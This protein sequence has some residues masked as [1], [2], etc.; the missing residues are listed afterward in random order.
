METF[1]INLPCHFDKSANAYYKTE[2]SQFIDLTGT[3][4]VGLSEI[5]F[6]KTWHNV[7]TKEH[8][9][10]LY[11]DINEPNGYGKSTN[12]EI[13]SISPGMYNVEELESLLKTSIRKNCET[14]EKINRPN[15][16]NFPE[17]LYPRFVYEKGKFKLKLGASPD[18]GYIF[19]LPSERLCELL[20]FDRN[21]IIVEAQ[22]LFESYIRKKI[23]NPHSVLFWYEKTNDNTWK[24]DKKY[25]EPKY[26]HKIEPFKNIYI[27]SD[28]CSDII[29]GSTKRNL[30]RIVNIP[31]TTKFG[32]NVSIIYDHPQHILINKTL[33]NSIDIKLRSD[34]NFKKQKEREENFI[35]FQEGY[36]IITLE[37]KKISDE[38]LTDVLARMSK[39]RPNHIKNVK[40]SSTLYSDR[41]SELIDS[42]INKFV[43]PNRNNQWIPNRCDELYFNQC[44]IIT[45]IKISPDNIDDEIEKQSEINNEENNKKPIEQIII[46]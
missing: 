16:F 36:V 6:S 17:I 32:E 22:T 7:E 21:E 5:L 15:L 28:I 31:S 8:I 45:P 12:I 27:L 18:V 38:E 33:F 35:E 13:S 2:F 43:T 42:S 30:L 44:R 19:A 46:K 23:E 9:E 1:Y 37:L 26:A 41:D 20:G 14:I 25:L 29:Y 34:L 24:Y 40:K 4:S 11:F 39:I 10:I 3:W